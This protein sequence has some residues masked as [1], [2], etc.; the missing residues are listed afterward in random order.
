MSRRPLIGMGRTDLA[1]G[2]MGAPL[3][4]DLVLYCI[5]KKGADLRCWPSCFFTRG[6]E[7]K[8]G[9]LRENYEECRGSEQR[10][11]KSQEEDE[12]KFQKYWY[13]AGLM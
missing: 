3:G 4:T 6:E 1:S 8:K 5:S 2:G 12:L 13:W 11:K 9:K 10:L 7:C